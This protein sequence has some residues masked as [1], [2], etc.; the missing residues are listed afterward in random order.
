MYELETTPKLTL[1][2]LPLIMVKIQRTGPIS[3][4]ISPTDFLLGTKVQSNKA[5]SM[6]KCRW[7]WPK[8]KVKG[9][10]QIF[11]KMGKNQRT[12][13][14]SEAISPT[15]FII[16]IFTAFFDLFCR[17]PLVSFVL[18]K[19]DR[20]SLTGSKRL[21]WLLPSC[22]IYFQSAWRDTR[23]FRIQESVGPLL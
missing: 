23:C 21:I 22:S 1:F 18:V 12:G 13:H 5:H 11:S 9:Q 20:F 3:E 7:S 19:K 4:A 15:D 14:V 16:T 17:C 10:G 6:T 8:I 2:S